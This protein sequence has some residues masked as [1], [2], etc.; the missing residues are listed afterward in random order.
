MAWAIYSTS[1]GPGFPTWKN[2]QI[3]L[4][5]HARSPGAVSDASLHSRQATQPSLSSAGNRHF[6]PPRRAC[7]L[8]SGA[9]GPFPTL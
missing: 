2:E 4:R 1:L 5:A 9:A 6:L 8:W 7:L 3:Q